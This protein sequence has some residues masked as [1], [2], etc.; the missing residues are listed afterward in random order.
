MSLAMLEANVL[1]GCM[2]YKDMSLSGI[3]G[4]E[5]VEQLRKKPDFQHAPIIAVTAY[6][7]SRRGTRKRGWMQCSPWQTI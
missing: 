5:A 4:W 3:S 1:G 7:T 2:W 6:V